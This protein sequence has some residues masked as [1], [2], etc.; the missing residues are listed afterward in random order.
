MDSSNKMAAY[1]R[2]GVNG[3]LKLTGVVDIFEAGVLLEAVRKSISDE[4]AKNIQVDMQN[5]ERVDI[6]TIQV[7]YRLKMECKTKSRK[8]EFMQMSQKISSELEQIGI[9]L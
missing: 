9:S 7:L 3:I 5:V 1:H 8:C 2:S 4:K 6:S